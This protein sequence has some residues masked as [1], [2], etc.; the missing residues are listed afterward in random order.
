MTL[1]IGGLPS[2]RGRAIGPAWR[3]VSGG[4]GASRQANTHLDRAAGG[5]APTTADAVREAAAALEGLAARLAEA[6]RVE[7]AAILEAQAVIAADPAL[8]DAARGRV[9]AGDDPALAVRRA[10]DA[11]ARRIE[12]AGDARVAARGADVRDVADRIARIVDGTAPRTPD[13]P[14][15]LVARDVP[16]V[17]ARGAAGVAG[18]WPRHRG[19]LQHVARR[20]LRAGPRDPHGGEC[21]R[22]RRGMRRG[23]RRGVAVDRRRRGRRR[24]GTEPQRGSGP[25]TAD[26]GAAGPPS[27]GAHVTA[28]GPGVTADGHRVHLVANIEGVADAE[29]AASAGAEGV[30]LYRTEALFL[31]RTAAPSEEEQRSV[32][33]RVLAALGPDRPV[34]IRLADLGGDKGV[35]YV[36]GPVEAN[37]FLGIRGIRLARRDRGLFVA[38]L[39]A[40]ARAAADARAAAL[41]MAPM[42]ATL[43]DVDLLV[44]LRDEAAASLAAAGTAAAAIRLGA[45]IEVPS[46][47]LLAAEIAARLDFLSIG[48]N[49][50][51]QYAL[52][53]DRGNAALAPLQDAL[54]PAVLRLVRTTVLGAAT[55]GRRSPCAVRSRATRPAR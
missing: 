5:D 7:E 27:A 34:V 15:I 10:G 47:A 50:L 23:R 54:H 37:P 33:R 53:V 8:V 38:Q 4:D 25:V 49:D 2:A 9:A 40:V 14:S 21:G 3:H 55:A 24:G 42:V 48:T 46:A 29:R 41:V 35:G 12:A 6:G 51:T 31:G 16:P 45:M 20:D 26:T 22:G 39:R 28:P 17:A 43:D 32:Y 44:S 52:A 1:R 18:P 11:I 36:P 19:G 13:R 30:G